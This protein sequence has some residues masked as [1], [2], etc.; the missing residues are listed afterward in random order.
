MSNNLSYLIGTRFVDG[1]RRVE[2]GFDCWGLV[3][4]VFSA[5]FSTELPDYKISCH[6]YSEIG[7]K[8][9]DEKGFWKRVDTPSAPS[10]VVMRFN[11]PF[12][13]HVGVY[14]GN[15]DFI[16]TALK[17]GVNIDSIHHFYWKRHIEGFY[18]PRKEVLD[19]VF[20][21]D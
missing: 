11:S 13:N 2:D 20:E 1:G 21:Q 18:V 14:I 7:A 8:I 5:H 12:C 19:S 15:G 6:N 9:E 10:L 4:H 17:M 3:K 16:H